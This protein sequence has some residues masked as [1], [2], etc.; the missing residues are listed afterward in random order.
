MAPTY[1]RLAWSRV[2][3]LTLR[4]LIE[5]LSLPFLTV[6]VSLLLGRFACFVV[7]NSRLFVVVECETGASNSWEGPGARTRDQRHC[8]PHV[9][10]CTRYFVDC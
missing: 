10:N 9:L 3:D 4:L 7:T 5:C 1:S 2:E 8:N 6:I